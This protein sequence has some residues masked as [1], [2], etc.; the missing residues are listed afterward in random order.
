MSRDFQVD[1][2]MPALRG[3]TREQQARIAVALDCAI[4]FGALEH[5]EG[6]SSLQS[7]DIVATEYDKK[8]AR[9]RSMS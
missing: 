7:M 9:L 1:F 4:A 8:V 5:A 3:L 2:L 6:N